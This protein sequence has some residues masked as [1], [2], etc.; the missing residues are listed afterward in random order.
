M[1]KKVKKSRGEIEKKEVDGELKKL[2][3][4][5]EKNAYGRNKDKLLSDYLQLFTPT[6]YE[7]AGLNEAL[8]SKLN[9]VHKQNRELEEEIK[10]MEKK[11]GKCCNLM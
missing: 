7:E 10:K 4:K 8:D 6:L 5:Y 1:L 9:K 11:N 3:D 2:I